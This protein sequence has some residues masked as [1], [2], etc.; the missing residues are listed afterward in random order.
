MRI[1][2][3]V[4]SSALFFREVECSRHK[5]ESTPTYSLGPD[6]IVIDGDCHLELVF[7][8]FSI[9]AFTGVLPCVDMK[10]TGGA[11][12]PEG[13][14]FGKKRPRGVWKYDLSGIFSG[15]IRT[16]HCSY[17]TAE[18][19]DH[20]F[21][22]LVEYARYRG[23]GTFGVNEAQICRKVYDKWKQALDLVPKDETDHREEEG[24][25][26]LNCLINGGKS[27]LECVTSVG[28]AVEDAQAHSVRSHHNPQL[29]T[30]SECL[31]KKIIEWKKISESANRR[32]RVRRLFGDRLALP[33]IVPTGEINDAWHVDECM[34]AEESLEKLG[35]K[36]SPSVEI[37]IC[38]G[39]RLLEERTQLSVPLSDEQ[40]KPAF[41]ACFNE[42]F[43]PLKG[44]QNVLECLSTSPLAHCSQREGT[45]GEEKVDSKS[46][47]FMSRL[48]IYGK[49]LKRNTSKHNPCVF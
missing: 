41:T 27:F 46:S 9:D 11:E 3:T 36:P 43:P 16:L 42:L 49:C 17:Y 5:G 30:A 22:R 28:T 2:F 23:K 29:S 40:T 7:P 38:V 37:A 48:W 20:N 18:L 31:Q 21:L 1:L 33:L 4:T 14:V 32:R 24:Q 19:T 25:K 44:G 13:D 39:K 35:I 12:P 45:L 47:A 26:L 34:K 15:R 6:G 10:E 8:A